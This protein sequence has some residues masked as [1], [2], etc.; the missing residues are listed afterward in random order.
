MKPVLTPDEAMDLDRASQARGVPAV[1]LMERAGRAVARAAI[2]VAA[3]VYGRRAVV[4]CG[5]GNN[6]GDG[7]VAARH[8]ARAGMRV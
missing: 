5:K 1:D 2:E 3:G 6:G 8:L 7:L 4:L